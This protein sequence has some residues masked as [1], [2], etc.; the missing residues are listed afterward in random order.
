MKKDEDIKKFIEDYGNLGDRG[1]STDKDGLPTEGAI[2]A[3]Y[4]DGDGNVIIKKHTYNMADNND[5]NALKQALENIAN[6]LHYGQ[7]EASQ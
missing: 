2:T 6:C 3:S 5:R 1:V 4:A 7:C